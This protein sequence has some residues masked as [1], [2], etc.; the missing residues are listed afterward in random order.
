MSITQQYLLDLHR[1]RAHGTPH[2]PAPGRHDLAVLRAVVRLLRR[3]ASWR[4]RRTSGGGSHHRG[5]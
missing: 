4:A 2:P 1:A 5:S 3:R